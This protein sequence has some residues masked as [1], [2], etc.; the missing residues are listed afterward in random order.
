MVD[1]RALRALQAACGRDPEL[2]ARL[3]VAPET[4][5]REHGVVPDARVTAARLAEALLG[6]HELTDADLGEL[7]GGCPPAALGYD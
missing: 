1:D 7:H 6:G 5:L 2:R 3:V 4:V